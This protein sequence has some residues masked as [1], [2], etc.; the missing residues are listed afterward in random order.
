M[1]TIAEQGIAPIAV[2]V[3]LGVW[4]TPPPLTATQSSLTFVQQV[5]EPGPPYQTT[6]VDSGGV[7]VPLTFAI[8]GSWLN[9]IN[10]FTLTP[11]PIQVGV[12][13]TPMLPGQYNGSFTV[14]SP[15][16][17]V[18][19]PVTLLVE[20]GPITPPV[21]SQVVNGASG[22]AGGVSPGEI[23]TVRG[24]SVGAS[25]TSGLMLNNSGLVASNLNGL[26][27]TFDGQAAPLI[28][29]SAN[30]TNLVVPYEVAGKTSTVIEITYATAAGTFDT[31]AWSLP[32]MPAALGLF[33]ID[34]TGTGQGAIVNQDG[35]INSA[36]NPAARGSV[37]SIY[38]TGE[39]QT[40]P[41]GV[42][43][44]VTGSGLK[45]PVLPVTVT[46]GGIQAVTQ[47]AG[48]APGSVA[49]LLQ[50]NAVVPQGVSPGSAVPLILSAGGIESQAG[51]TIAV[52]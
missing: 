33:T 6:E 47:Y 18:Y 48:S 41:A 3:T 44:S 11:A 23:L 10:R 32:V 30:Q 51:V 16:S 36:A 4:S 45:M 20:P 19:V 46:I 39:G 17:S 2:P 52:N 34:S 14:T 8:G 40:T 22:I 9:L 37:I 1:V 27:V 24:Y 28:Y 12:V 25:A 7:P 43:G 42:T 26:Q 21:L 38:A 35:S 29:T 49:G 50:V 31:K 15:G 13:Q 5:G